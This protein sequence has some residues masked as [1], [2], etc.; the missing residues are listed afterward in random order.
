MPRFWDVPVI[1]GSIPGWVSNN[2]GDIYMVK[3]SIYRTLTAAFLIG[4]S[5]F[6]I[7]LLLF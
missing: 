4:S 7:A 5:L 6:V 3:F 2:E 1:P